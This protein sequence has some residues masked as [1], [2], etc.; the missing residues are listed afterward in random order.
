[1]ERGSSREQ[2]LPVLTDQHAS[3]G[4]AGTGG[5]ACGPRGLRPLRQDRHAVLA[6]RSFL[7][8]SRPS[9]SVISIWAGLLAWS[10]DRSAYG[11]FRSSPAFLRLLSR[12]QC[13]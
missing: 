2:G 4:K 13:K 6:E 10:R 7:C 11:I 5:L 8:L 1:M 3:P 9:R 12:R